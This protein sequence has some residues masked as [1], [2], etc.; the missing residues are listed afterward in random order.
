VADLL[1]IWST[2]PGPPRALA[3]VAQALSNRVPGKYSQDSVIDPPATRSDV[4]RRLRANPVVFYFGHGGRRRLGTA[5]NVL[6]DTSNVSQVGRLLIAVA[7]QAGVELG[8]LDYRNVTGRAFVGFAC[9]TYHPARSAA[10]ANQAYESALAGVFASCTA[11][12]VA[13]D[14]RS[15]LLA[16]A[17]DY[18][19]NRAAYRL[20]LADAFVVY[21]GL[22]S[23]SA[24]VGAYGDGSVTL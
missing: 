12:Q 4:D 20:P 9:Q 11:A 2:L 24:G 8:R 15:E 16:A 23:N 13:D 19:N 7:C 5:S 3:P 21:L 14:L 22:R 17:N 6:I 1:F 10:R 18:L